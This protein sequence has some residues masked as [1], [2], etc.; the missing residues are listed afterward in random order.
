MPQPIAST[1]VELWYVALAYNNNNSPCYVD[2]V[3][4]M[5][6]L[7]NGVFSCTIKVNDGNICDYL[8]MENDS[9]VDT[10]TPKVNKIP[11]R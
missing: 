4:D 9:Y 10:T 2:M 11:G 6:R 7:N 3:E 5:R 8:L 1:V